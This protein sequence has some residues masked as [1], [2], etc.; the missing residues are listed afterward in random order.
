[1]LNRRFARAR[2]ALRL[3]RAIAAVPDLL[4]ESRQLGKYEARPTSGLHQLFSRSGV[5]TSW[6]QPTSS[7]DR[8]SIPIVA[9]ARLRAE[10]VA[11]RRRAVMTVAASN[12]RP[13][14]WNSSARNATERATVASNPR[15]KSPTD[16]ARH[17]IT[18]KDRTNAP[19]RT[20]PGIPF[21][22]RILIQPEWAW[23]YSPSRKKDM[24]SRFSM[25]AQASPN[26]PVPTPSGLSRKIRQPPFAHSDRPLVR[27]PIERPESN[28]ELN[29]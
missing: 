22:E 15:G 11:P 5:R 21:S 6:F 1:M 16:R 18:A 10:L 9:A 24:P 19:R 14:A 7:L 26:P 4:T 29:R 23:V 20:I 8:R 3:S 25:V 17:P 27:F 2:V 28:R 13:L 12:Q